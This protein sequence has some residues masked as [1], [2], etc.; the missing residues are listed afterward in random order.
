MEHF[1]KHRPTPII[2][3]LITNKSVSI[4]DFL[5]PSKRIKVLPVNKVDRYLPVDDKNCSDV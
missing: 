3:P 2:I 5:I 1:K 4:F